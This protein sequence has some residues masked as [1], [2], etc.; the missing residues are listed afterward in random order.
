MDWWFPFLTIM[1]HTA[2]I[3][4]PNKGIIPLLLK[5]FVMFGLSLFGDTEKLD[6]ISIRCINCKKGPGLYLK[7][8]NI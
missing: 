6:T 2:N 7:K 8:I 5:I 1:E 4:N 3:I